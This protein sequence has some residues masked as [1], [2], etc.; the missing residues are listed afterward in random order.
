MERDGSSGG[1]VRMAVISEEGVERQV[2]L[3][4]ELPKFS[5]V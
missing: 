5:T 3:G 2:I 1:V 4:N